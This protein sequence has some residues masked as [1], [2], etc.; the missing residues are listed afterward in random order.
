[1]IGELGI[2]F[3]DDETWINAADGIENMI[4]VTIDVDGKRLINCSEA[5]EWIVH[6]L[7]V[8]E[9]EKACIGI[10]GAAKTA[11]TVTRSWP[12][13]I[14]HWD[15]LKEHDIGV[16]S[17]LTWDEI[18]QKYPETAKAYQVDRNWDAVEGAETLNERRSRGLRVV[19]T[20]IERHAN[21]DTVMLCAVLSVRSNG[22]EYTCVGSRPSP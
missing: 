20:V 12:I 8:E 7:P 2:V 14:E 9:Y 6:A 13:N 17:G 3:K 5:I 10:A 16:F 4:I 15:D 19:D 11:H 22:L 1:M 21:D 18:T